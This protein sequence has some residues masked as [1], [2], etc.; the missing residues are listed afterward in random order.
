M[1]NEKTK[2]LTIIVHIAEKLMSDI[3]KKVVLDKK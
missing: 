2:A 1:L 3:S